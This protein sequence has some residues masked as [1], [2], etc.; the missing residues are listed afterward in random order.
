MMLLYNQFFFCVSVKLLEVPLYT[1]LSIK[2]EQKGAEK[3]WQ[4]RDAEYNR[5]PN[6]VSIA[7]I[8]NS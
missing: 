6:S 4:K 1:P 8:N 5:M 2:W 7:T 3:R